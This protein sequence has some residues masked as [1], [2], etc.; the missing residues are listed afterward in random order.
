MGIL[1]QR[2]YTGALIPCITERAL[3]QLLHC[4]IPKCCILERLRHVTTPVIIVDNE[5]K[6]T[7]DNNRLHGSDVRPYAIDEYGL[8]II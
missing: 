4:A 3:V 1:G 8:L 5:I 7:K 2:T 6:N